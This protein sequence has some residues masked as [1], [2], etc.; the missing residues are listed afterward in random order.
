LGGGV[1]VFE[2]FFDLGYGLGFEEGFGLEGLE[3]LQKCD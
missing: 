1:A 3:D 2:D